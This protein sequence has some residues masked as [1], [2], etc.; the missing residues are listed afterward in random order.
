MSAARSSRKVASLPEYMATL[1]SEQ[2]RVLRQVLALIQKAVPAAESTISYSIPAFKLERVFIY[3]AAFKSHIGIFPPVRDAKLRAELKPYANAKGNLRFDLEK[4]IPRALIARVARALAKQYQEAGGI[5]RKIA[6]AKT[7]AKAKASN[8][9]PA[10]P[11]TRQLQIRLGRMTGA[12]LHPMAARSGS[13]PLAFLYKVMGKMFAIVS[14]RGEEF[15]ILKCDPNLVPVLRQ[16]Y[17]GVG[18]RSHL[19][20]RYWISVDLDADVPAREI[21]RLVDHSHGLVVAGLTAKQRAQLKA[22]ARG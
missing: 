6:P 18:H 12:T 8:K 15:V 13:P 10:G 16:Q 20:K 1:S 22:Q 14:A 7:K 9:P 4:P 19:D 21:R 2:S 5:R 17:Q 11:K 3:A